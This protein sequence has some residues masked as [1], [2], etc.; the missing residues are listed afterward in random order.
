MQGPHQVA[1]KSRITTLP[2]SESRLTLPPARSAS[3]KAGAAW[4]SAGGAF[5]Q[6]EVKTGP[7]SAA[8]TSRTPVLIRIF[9]FYRRRGPSAHPGQAGEPAGEILGEQGEAVGHEQ[10]A[11]P[12]QERARRVLHR[13]H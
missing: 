7:A 10:H 11:D 5:M 8:D 9:P 4:T 2:F 13:A 1:Q 3:S 12:D 6:A